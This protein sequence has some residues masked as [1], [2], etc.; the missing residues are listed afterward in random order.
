MVDVAF[1]HWRYLFQEEELIRYG[2]PHFDHKTAGQALSAAVR[3]GADLRSSCDLTFDP[4][5]VLAANEVF[6]EAAV[7]DP[8]ADLEIWDEWRSGIRAADNIGCD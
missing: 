3:S 1:Q 6:P 8:I 7:A 5:L 4:K 2:S